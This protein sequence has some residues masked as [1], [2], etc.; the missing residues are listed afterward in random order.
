MLKTSHKRAFAKEFA[1]M[2]A[3]LVL[4]FGAVGIGATLTV[5]YL[6]GGWVAGVVAGAVVFGGI[7]AAAWVVS[8][9][10]G[11]GRAKAD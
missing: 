1:E 10:P 9:K 2:N 6:D 8:A 3:F 5:K 4:V 11:P 7:T